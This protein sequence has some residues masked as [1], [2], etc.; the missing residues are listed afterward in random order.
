MTEPSYRCSD[1]KF[2]VV[3][4]PWG[5]NADRR[6]R[7]EREKWE[8]SFPVFQICCLMI[9]CGWLYRGRMFPFGQ[10][11][12]HHDREK[13]HFPSRR[14]SPVS[15]APRQ[16]LQNLSSTSIDKI[17][18]QQSPLLQ[19]LPLEIRRIIYGFVVGGDTICLSVVPFRVSGHAPHDGQLSQIRHSR[20]E[21][22]RYDLIR[23]DNRF[24]PRRTALLKSCRQIYAEAI[25]MLYSTNTFLITNLY[26]LFAFV[27]TILPRRFHMIQAIQV[28]YIFTFAVTP[29]YRCY[30]RCSL[31]EWKNFWTLIA[32]MQ[33]LR[34]LTVQ[35][36]QTEDGVAVADPK[37]D[38][39]T[40]TLRPLMSI[41]GLRKFELDY[42][43]F[44]NPQY[45]PTR[46][47][48]LTSANIKL[49]QSLDQMVKQPRPN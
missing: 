17:V 21:M 39:E 42:K 20:N 49:R 14:T 27:K 29:T 11:R 16:E 3:D 9:P 30:I 2:G 18:D 40:T 38:I 43:K 6:A 22:T 25:D 34:Y 36:E 32:S 31:Q 28:T 26:I 24:S 47:R 7:D 37:E 35:L 48:P 4:F 5:P 13:S 12:N 8:S 44:E 46:I 19:R 33:G 15:L 23:A 41:R 1:M 45:P 10:R